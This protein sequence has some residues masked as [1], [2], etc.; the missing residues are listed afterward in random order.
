MSLFG[1]SHEKP[2]TKSR[3]ER[4]HTPEPPEP[5]SDVEEEFGLFELWPKTPPGE[6]N[7]V[8]TVMESVS[9]TRS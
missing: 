2:Q 9:P 3:T 6:V 1:H 7:R 5:S 4:A 8:P